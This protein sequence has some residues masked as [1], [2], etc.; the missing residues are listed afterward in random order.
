MQEV[1]VQLPRHNMPPIEVHGFRFEEFPGLVIT[2][3]IESWDAVWPLPERP[4]GVTHF[5]SGQLIAHCKDKAHAEQVMAELAKL[6][7]DWMLQPDQINTTVDVKSART[8]IKSEA[9]RLKSEAEEAACESLHL[10]THPE[11]PAILA[12]APVS[13]E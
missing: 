11:L 5:L 1:K 2:E 13:K 4:W 7:V 9:W 6:P 3:S 8:R 12:T 10:Y